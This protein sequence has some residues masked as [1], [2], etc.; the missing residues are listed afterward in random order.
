MKLTVVFLTILLFT[1]FCCQVQE[2]VETN[3]VG[4]AV[5]GGGEVGVEQAVAAS[6]EDRQ[7]LR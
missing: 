6:T 1:P 2:L 4:V 7:S 5:V 3:L